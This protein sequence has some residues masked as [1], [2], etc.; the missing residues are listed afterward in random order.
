M[1]GLEVS[2]TYS[3]PSKG[4]I[5][6]GADLAGCVNVSNVATPS[7]ICKGDTHLTG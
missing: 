5:G 7:G 4:W 2:D 1:I 6:K 3:P